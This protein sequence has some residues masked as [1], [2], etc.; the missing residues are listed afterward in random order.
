MTAYADKLK[1]PRW[2][3]K[4]LEILERDKWACQ[5]CSDDESE[6]H[7]HHRTYYPDTEPWDY[8]DVELVTLCKSCHEYESE[9]MSKAQKALRYCLSVQCGF[10]ADDIVCL[11]RAFEHIAWEAFLPSSPEVFATALEWALQSNKMV[12]T[13]CREYF[14][15]LHHKTKR[16]KIEAQARVLPLKV[17][18]QITDEFAKN[19]KEVAVHLKANPPEWPEG[20]SPDN[21]NL[22]P[23][24]TALLRCASAEI[25]N[26]GTLRIRFAVGCVMHKTL[27][28][29]SERA[30]MISAAV[31]TQLGG[32]VHIEYEL[33]SG[34]EDAAHPVYKT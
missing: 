18:E 19:T 22:G 31:A 26:A 7:V 28:E 10:L 24:T 29:A 34:V 27:C 3:R 9:V 25:T 30:Q 15:H 17:S 12:E 13:I 4:R 20:L 21:L 1:D 11:I 32:P 33:M 16:G 2:Q 14:D 5:R 6:L 23:A 8:A